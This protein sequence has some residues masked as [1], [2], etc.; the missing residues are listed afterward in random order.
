MRR[1]VVLIFL[2]VVGIVIAMS[3]TNRQTTHRS[4]PP[5]VR[6]VVSEVRLAFD[7]DRPSIPFT[8]VY[9]YPKYPLPGE[10][11]VGGLKVAVWQDGTVVR[12]RSTAEVGKAYIQ[13]RLKPEQ[14]DKVVR[15]IERAG[16]LATRPD[17]SSPM[18]AASDVLKI[19]TRGGPVAWSHSVPAKENAQVKQIEE[20]LAT[21]DISDIRPVT[22]ESRYPSEWDE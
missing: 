10:D 21:I 1:A 19:R 3:L 20:M 6:D 4:G 11:V 8:F 16:I 15:S 17:E 13:G 18:H 7:K 12:A 2:A 9:M 14:L 5:A 22:W